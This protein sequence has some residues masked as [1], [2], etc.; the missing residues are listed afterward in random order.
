M[1][2]IYHGNTLIINSMARL[3]LF[4]CDG[5]HVA[6]LRK[7]SPQGLGLYSRNWLHCDCGSRVIIGDAMS[8][9]S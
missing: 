1:Q 2:N 9:A 5:V 4:T 3:V 6:W 8:T 7:K